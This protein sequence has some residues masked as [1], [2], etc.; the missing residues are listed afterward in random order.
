M[1]SITA[2]VTRVGDT[3]TSEGVARSHHVLIDRPEAKGGLDRWSTSS[4]PSPPVAASSTT[5]LR[6]A[7]SSRCGAP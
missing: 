3:S 7:W 6:P 2:T 4:W 5:R 1:A